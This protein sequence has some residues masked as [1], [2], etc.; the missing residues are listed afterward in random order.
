MMS[1][2]R[3]AGD[4]RGARHWGG[5]VALLAVLLL[6]GCS[7]E[8]ARLM[9]EQYPSYSDQ[10]KRAIDNGYLLRGMTQDQVFLTLG[11]PVCKKMIKADGRDL[12]VWMYPPSGRTPCT[13]AQHRVYFDTGVVDS[14][15]LMEAPRGGGG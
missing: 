2:T 7:S 8:R 9:K 3:R 1:A 6:A 12:E 5:I 4:R 15:K 14:W 13:T 11:E 10:V